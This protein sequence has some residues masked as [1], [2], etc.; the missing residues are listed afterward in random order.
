MMILMMIWMTIQ[1]KKPP[2]ATKKSTPLKT[3]DG[4]SDVKAPAKKS[5]KPRSSTSPLASCKRSGKPTYLEM[6]HKAI[7]ALKDHTGS[8]APAISK[9]IL[10][11]NEHANSTPPNI[12]TS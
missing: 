12:I 4:S 9:W 7:V 1:Q 11:N 6:A 10:A 5:P 2:A 8:S 3:D